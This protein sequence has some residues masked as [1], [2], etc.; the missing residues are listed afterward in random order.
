MTIDDVKAAWNAQA[1]ELNQWDS[2]SAD[3]RVEFAIRV[4]EEAWR[5]ALRIA[6]AMNAPVEG[7]E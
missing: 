7:K 3:E 2:L 5:L 4:V 6:S 1:D